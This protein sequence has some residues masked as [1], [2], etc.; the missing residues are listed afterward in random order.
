MQFKKAKYLGVLYNCE[1]K[2]IQQVSN[3]C[4]IG[5]RIRNL[6][7]IRK[8]LDLKTAKMA[9]AAFTTTSLDYCNA[10]L[11]GLPKNQIHKIQLVQNSA[12]RVVVGLKSMIIV[13]KPGKNYTGY[14]LKPDVNSK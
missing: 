8:L 3:I 6:A 4:K 1:G 14:Q 7:A 13:C 5:Y 12:V 10:L 2:L 9:A 11:H